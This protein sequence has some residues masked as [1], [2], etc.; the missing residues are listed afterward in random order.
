MPLTLTYKIDVKKIDKTA[1]FIGAKGTYL[2]GAFM[3]NKDGVDQYGNHG[4]ITQNISKERRDAGE[5]GPIIGNWKWGKD[6]RKESAPVRDESHARRDNEGDF[7]R[8]DSGAPF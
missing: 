1:L 5:R 3:D 4:F 6:A 2:D 7:G 8:D